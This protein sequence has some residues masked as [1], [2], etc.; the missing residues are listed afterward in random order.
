MEDVHSWAKLLRARPT[1]TIELQRAREHVTVVEPDGTVSTRTRGGPIHYMGH[2]D[3][4]E[5]K[6]VRVAR[7]RLPVARHRAMIEGL[8]EASFPEGKGDD[9]LVPDE[10]P[11]YISLRHGS[12]GAS[13]SATHRALQANLP[14]HLVFAELEGLT[15][16]LS[17]AP[18]TDFIENPEREEWTRVRDRPPMALGES[19]SVAPDAGARAQKA[20][21]AFYAQ[22]FDTLC[23]RIR[24]LPR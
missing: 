7:A 10:I 23:K 8:I 13:I 5:L 22:H 20:V 19:G 4:F 14:L 12:E 6:T 2:L 21:D 11:S 1:A 15:T 3:N 17:A 24:A 9:Y 16:A 18:A